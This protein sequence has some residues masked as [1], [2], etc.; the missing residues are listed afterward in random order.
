MARRKRNNPEFKVFGISSL[1]GNAVEATGTQYAPIT[2]DSVQ[3]VPLV[4]DERVDEYVSEL[5]V[6][7]MDDQDISLAKQ[8]VFLAEEE[9]RAKAG[10]IKL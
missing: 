9:F 4:Y 1:G 7:E 6:M 5:A 2:D 8:E 10:Y 3:K